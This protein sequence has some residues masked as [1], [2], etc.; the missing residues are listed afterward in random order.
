MKILVAGL[1]NME[2]TL[3]IDSFP[4]EYESVRFTGGAV[5][6]QVSGVGYNITKALTT[7]GNEVRF[8]SMVGDD[9]IGRLIQQTLISEGISDNHI[10]AKLPETP[11][12]VILYEPSGRRAIFSDLKTIRDEAYPEAQFREALADCELAI[13]ANIPFSRPFLSIAKA[14]NIPIATDVHAIQNLDDDYN[15]DYMTLADIV[16]MSHEKL[17]IAPKE[18]ASQVQSR[19]ST[20]IIVIGMGAE[21]ALLTVK[22]DNRVEMIPPKVLRPIVNTVGSGDAL[23]SAFNHVYSKTCDPYLAIRKAVLFAGYKIGSAS[24]S[25]GFLTNDE[26]EAYYQQEYL[27]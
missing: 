18:W 22:D 23:F 12:S 7:L 21:G 9:V 10:L 3:R 11:Q 25:E 19:Y 1:V 27:S 17:P 2:T 16:F 8:L 6:S 4:I 5:A 13:L 14:K 26:L 24:G 20:P 15:R